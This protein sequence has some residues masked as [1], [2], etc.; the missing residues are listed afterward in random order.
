MAGTA[1]GDG[2]MTLK[3]TPPVIPSTCAR[4]WSCQTHQPS[5]S[6]A[7]EETTVPEQPAEP[8][9]HRVRALEVVPDVQH[10][11]AT[12]GGLH[13]AQELAELRVDGGR[14]GSSAAVAGQFE[15]DRGRERGR[16]RWGD[17]E[18]VAGL[19]APRCAEREVVGGA[20]IEP[21]VAGTAPVR[22]EPVVDPIA[23]LARLDVGELDPVVGD[24]C[25]ID[26]VLVRGDV[27]PV[28]LALPQR[29]SPVRHPQEPPSRGQRQQQH[30]GDP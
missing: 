26:V 3:S 17:G 30:A 24:S 28:P 6:G 4:P 27:D 23:T 11:V 18:E 9:A 29:W 2:R 1:S 19:C 7:Q 25:P 5:T 21:G 20:A 8:F 14:V 16:V 13:G 12:P 22:L 10:D 15:V